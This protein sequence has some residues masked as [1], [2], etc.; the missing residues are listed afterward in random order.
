MGAPEG[1]DIGSLSARRAWIEMFL[2]FKVTEEKAKVALRKESVDRNNEL[3]GYYTASLQSLSARR[4]WIEMLDEI[5]FLKNVGRSLS[6]RRAWIEIMLSL[7]VYM[8]ATVALRKE[9][10]DR[11]ANTPPQ[12]HQTNTVALRKESVDRNDRWRTKEDQNCASLSARRA[13]IEMYYV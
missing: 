6:A 3:C 4:A 5:I 10:V 7:A 13:W 2:E 11:N 12:E 8:R 1:A 9:S